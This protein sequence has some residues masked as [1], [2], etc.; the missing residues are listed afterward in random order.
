MKP[1]SI[2]APRGFRA[3]AFAVALL[4][5]GCQAPYFW[6]LN[7][8]VPDRPTMS[9]V[10][11]AKHDL[12]LDIY[13]PLTAKPRAIVVFFYGGSWRN[14]Y[15]AD[16][17]FVG[18]ALAQRGLLVII[19]DYRKAPADTFPAFMDDAAAAVAWTKA[20]AADFGADPAQ[21]YLM[22]H[23][24]GAH[25][26][27]LLGTDG[28]YLQQV[29]MKPRDLKGVIGLAGPYDFL[30]ITNRGVKQVFGAPDTWPRSQPVNFVNGDEPPFLLLHGADDGKVFPRNSESLAEKL[31][32]A[33]EPVSLKIIPDVGHIGLVNG[34]RSPRLSP[35]L[36]DTV[37]WIEAQDTAT[38]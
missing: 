15:R 28:S 36:A 18:S 32:A 26:V 19:P 12:S 2:V 24:A 29:G 25:I 21:I 38:R 27:A 13:R 30:P 23:S 34:F 17:R 14:G 35:V 5:A 6:A 33:G 31:R 16:Y 1:Q 10:F 20:H 8:G 22:G 9:A 7:A 4:L 11:D 37:Q 3:A